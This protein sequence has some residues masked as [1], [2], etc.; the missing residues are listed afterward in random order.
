MKR[1]ITIHGWEGY[2]EGGWRPWLRQKLLKK[3]IEVVNPAMPNTKHPK[4][5]KWVK[6][7]KSVIGTPSDNT[8]LVGHSLGVITILRYL[9]T[10]KAGERIGGAIFVAGFSSDLNYEGYKGELSSF[11]KTLVSW[12]KVK[13]HCNNFIILHSKD[14][15]WVPL[16]H[17]LL[18]EEKLRVKAII[19]DGMKHY[20]GDDGITE[21]PILI[22]LIDGLKS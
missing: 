7:L 17:A 12:N 4:M 21:L 13:K 11:F 19:Q 22:E 20:S 6:H 3:G 16:K 18:M 8:V 14:D 1:V 15:P 5:N 9:E 2:P 10:L